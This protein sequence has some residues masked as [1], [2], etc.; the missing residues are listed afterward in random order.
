MI[1]RITITKK[2]G[3]YVAHY[4][5]GE[6]LTIDPLGHPRYVNVMFSLNR[7]GWWVRGKHEAWPDLDAL[8]AELKSRGYGQVAKHQRD[9][10]WFLTYNAFLQGAREYPISKVVS[11][12]PDD[13]PE[14]DRTTPCG[15]D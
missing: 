3:D 12:V 15:L 9:D 14:D 8:L 10:V 6:L 11:V 2:S 1:E 5:H 4:E 13:T 7:S